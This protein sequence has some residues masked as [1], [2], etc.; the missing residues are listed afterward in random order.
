MAPG[1]KRLVGLALCAGL[2]VACDALG[3]DTANGPATDGDGAPDAGSDDTRV[4]FVSEQLGRGTW[5]FF[6]DPPGSATALH[7][8]SAAIVHDCLVVGDAVVIWRPMHRS[9]VD[10]L[11]VRIDAG[12]APTVR[13]GG[14]GLSLEEDGPDNFPP[15]VVE[16]CNPTEVHFAADD[17]AEILE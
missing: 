16:R 3:D 4:D 14:G 2:L 1:G 7:Q 6:H 11:L 15:E 5:V 12:E 10:E 9:T 17:P 13:V 8:G